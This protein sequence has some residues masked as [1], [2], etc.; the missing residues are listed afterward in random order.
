MSH[1][2]RPDSIPYLR[3][4]TYSVGVYVCITFAFGDEDFTR[5]GGESGRAVE[6]RDFRNCYGYP[7]D[8]TCV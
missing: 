6:C 3:G 7:I 2:C 5:C 4:R 1:M 8:T